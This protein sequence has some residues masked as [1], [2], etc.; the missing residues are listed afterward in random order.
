M[1]QEI[2][3]PQFDNNNG[4]IVYS[5]SGAEVAIDC[6]ITPGIEVWLRFK[7]ARVTIYVLSVDGDEYVGSIERMENYYPNGELSVKDRVAFKREHVFVIN[8]NP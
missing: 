3:R 2:K 5:G 4:V 8:R 1:E 6:P 7:G